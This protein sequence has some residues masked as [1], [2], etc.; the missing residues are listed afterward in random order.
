MRGRMQESPHAL[1]KVEEKGV[2]HALCKIQKEVLNEK[3]YFPNA[4]GV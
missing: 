3:K 4:L 2:M 1:W